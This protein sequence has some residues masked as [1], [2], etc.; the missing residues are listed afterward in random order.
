MLCSSAVHCS[1]SL[2]HEALS[3]GLG[4]RSWNSVSVLVLVLKRVL[5]VTLLGLFGPL[6]VGLGL[7][8]ESLSLEFRLAN[9]YRPCYDEIS[10]LT[11][12]PSH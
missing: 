5:F 8:L 3:I 2:G 9:F 10:K 6:G 11:A 7:G 12:S 4:V 1:L